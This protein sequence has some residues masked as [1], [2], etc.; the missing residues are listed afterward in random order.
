MALEFVRRGAS[1]AVSARRT[2]RLQALVTEIEA[3][4]GK[5][6]AIACD[7]TQAE[8]LE[9]AV[10]GVVETFGRLDVAVANAGFGVS[11]RIESL[12]ADEWRLQLE[13]NVIGAAMTAKFALPHLRETR[14][15]LALVGSVAGTICTPRSGA[16]S[17]SK[18][19]VRALGQTLAME[20]YGSGVSCTTLQPG[21][22]H[23]EI[24]QV[25]NAGRF[26]GSRNDRRPSR[27]MWP[28]E[29]A[30]K[31]MVRAIYKRRREYT[32]TGHGRLG[33]WL[34]RHMPGLVHFVTTRF[35][36][37]RAARSSKV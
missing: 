6:L 9:R 32:F 20:L 31:V 30:A 2:D 19:A 16:Y 25:D 29:R 21:F 15:R 14:G 17:A 22:V 7:V 13:T 37:A 1:V 24:A 18:Y 35:G 10:A 4:G 23:S 5:A 12:T 28:T 26:D 27:L 11:G 36:M 33:A 3:S 8:T 34:G